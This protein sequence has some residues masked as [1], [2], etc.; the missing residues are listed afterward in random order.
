MGAIVAY[1]VALRLRMLEAQQPEHLIVSARAAP[2]LEKSGEPLR[3]LDNERFIETLHQTYGAVP[4]AIRKSQELQNVF[5]PILRADVELLETHVDAGAKPLDCPV[6]AFGGDADRAISA[7][8]LAGWRERTAGDFSQFEFSG[9][10]FFIHSAREKVLATVID[11]L[12]NS[13]GEKE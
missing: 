2:H 9:D 3:H 11:C 5:L 6:T 13:S 8:M 1:E 10:H 4:E 7:A 12:P